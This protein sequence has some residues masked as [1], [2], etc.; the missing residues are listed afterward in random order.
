MI[1][2]F[3]HCRY[4]KVVHSQLQNLE[5]LLNISKYFCQS[6]VLEQISSSKETDMQCFRLVQIFVMVVDNVHISEL[7][8]CNDLF[9]EHH[10][11]QLISQSKKNLLA[12]LINLSI[13]NCNFF[14]FSVLIEAGKVANFLEKD[15]QT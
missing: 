1:I 14:A 15:D 13:Y 11:N 5:I 2:F 4:I 8:R 3:A 12:L 9:F 10:P 6:L 7:I